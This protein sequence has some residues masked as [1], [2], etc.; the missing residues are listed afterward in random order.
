M[1]EDNYFYYWI[2]DFGHFYEVKYRGPILHVTSQALGSNDSNLDQS[3]TSIQIL[4]E[5]N[6]VTW[7]AFYKITTLLSN[8]YTV[9]TDHCQDKHF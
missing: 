6:A 8:L 7:H 9:P 1:R 3:V 5:P 4:P 2:C